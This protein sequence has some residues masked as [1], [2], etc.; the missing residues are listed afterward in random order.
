MASLSISNFSCIASATFE[1]APVSI[2]IGPQGS[3]KSVTTKLLYFLND[4]LMNFPQFAER[5]ESFEDFKRALSKQF[6]I[7]FPASAWGCHR[8]IIN[9]TNGPFTARVLRRSKARKLQDEVS[10]AFSP[11][12]EKE[13]RAAAELFEK[14]NERENLDSDALMQVSFE[15]SWRLREAITNRI[16]VALEGAFVSRQTFIPAG[17]AFFTS[18]GRLVA[19]LEQVGSLDQVTIKFARIFASIRDQHPSRFIRRDG[20]DDEYINKRS[21]YMNKFF[22]GEINFGR[23]TE[24]VAT[25][26][27]RRVP[28]ASLSSGQQELLPMWSLI[29]YYNQMDGRRIL[30]NSRRS[31]EILYIEEPEAH[32]FPSAQ[33]LLMEFLISS[34]ARGKVSRKLVITTHSP[35]IMSQ[36]NVFLK[37]GQ[38]AR[39]KKKNTEIN[40]IVPREC[41]LTDDQ[42]SAYCIEEGKFRY[43]MDEDGLI[44]GRYLDAISEQISMDFSKL[45]KIESEL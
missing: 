34:I 14:S 36:L 43:I 12:F 23:E 5:G 13:Y 6:A 33:S 44:D 29:D 37:A 30:P 7:W 26:D 28:F 9:Y 19:G 45:L 25:D 38:L 27:G 22:G 18:I 21:M 15:K 4:I 40:S 2:I 8:F 10:F 41:W 16:A 3:G 32:L 20:S 1:I 42:V 39:R 11:W 17:R 35:Y 24:F 31:G